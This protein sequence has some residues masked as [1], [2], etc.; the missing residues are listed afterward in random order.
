MN[1]KICNISHH[2]LLMTHNTYFEKNNLI[3]NIIFIPLKAG[4]LEFHF[5]VMCMF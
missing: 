4:F 2:K 1:F 5:D 3:E